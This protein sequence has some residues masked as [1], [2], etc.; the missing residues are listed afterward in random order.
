[1]QRAL[2]WLIF[3]LTLGNQPTYAQDTIEA[4]QGRAFAQSTCAVCHGIVLGAPSPVAGA[5]NFH[6]IAATPGMSPLALRVMLETP[7]RSMPNLQLSADE[8]RDVTAYI[9]S[10]RAK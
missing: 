5:P 8:L 9:M 7:H 2:V 10:L 6:T 1:M 4:R 3:T